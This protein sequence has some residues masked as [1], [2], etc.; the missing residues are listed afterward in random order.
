M[1][2]WLPVFVFCLDVVKVGVQLPPCSLK[3]S[4]GQM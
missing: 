3:V 1:F 4:L 2:S